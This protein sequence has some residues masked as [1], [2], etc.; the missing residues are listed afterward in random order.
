MRLS[1]IF[2]F[3]ATTM[4]SRDAADVWA[5]RETEAGTTGAKL[6]ADAP[7]TRA[8]AKMDLRVGAASRRAVSRSAR[9]AEPR[10][11]RP[12]NYQTHRARGGNHEWGSGR[13]ASGA[14]RSAPRPPHNAIFAFRADPAFLFASP[15][16][17]AASPRPRV[18]Q[19]YAS[20]SGTR[21]RVCVPGP[22]RRD[23]AAASERPVGPLFHMPADTLC[24]PS[25]TLP[26]ACTVASCFVAHASAA[27]SFTGVTTGR[28]S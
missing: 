21:V 23:H 8:R 15:S 25:R 26:S 1:R 9:L 5:R 12:R 24:M 7:A 3:L 10:T 27:G 22:A 6:N 17:Q 13:R 19:S 20:S 14:R 11:W 2:A 4:L 28:R 18:Q 16:S